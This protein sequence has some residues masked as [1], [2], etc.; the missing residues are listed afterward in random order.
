MKKD[1]M[2]I[3]NQIIISLF[4]LAL[5]ACGGSSDGSSKAPPLSIDEEAL[6]S[7]VGKNARAYSISG[8]CN[9]A[10]GDITVSVTESDV[11]GTLTCSEEHS[12]SGTVDFSALVPDPATIFIS[13]GEVS[14]QAAPVVNQS[15]YFITKWS[16][17][18]G[19]AF[20]L[21]LVSG[22]T[23]DFIVDWGD[24]DNPCVVDTTCVINSDT[25]G[26]AT[27]TYADE[28]DYT[29]IIKG[30]LD[31]FQN[32]GVT[33]THLKEVSNLGNVGWK[34]LSS[35]FEGNT[36]L[37]KFYGGNTSE[38]TNMSRMFANA[39]LVTPYVSG[40]D[41]SV[42]TDMSSMFEG[43]AEAQPYTKFWDTSAVTNMSMM[44][45]GAV[46]AKPKATDWDTSAVANMASMFEG[47]VEANPDTMDWD[48]SAV[49]NMSMMFKGA[50]EAEPDTSTWITSAV[51][52]MSEMFADATMANPDTTT[53]TFPAVTSFA[54]MFNVGSEGLSPENYS[55]FLQ[56]LNGNKPT[57]AITDT[58]MKTFGETASLIP[59]SLDSADT[60]GID[61]LTALESDGYVFHDEPPI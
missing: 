13:Q 60:D 8:D 61:A 30:A 38:V 16:F 2:S 40:W 25:D 44:F 50:L 32:A 54:Q 53:W 12:Y 56:S 45:K 41:T 51:T 58:L 11:K 52:D 19:Q 33:A 10:N 39:A 4:C 15:Q 29:I 37:T 35:A 36:E 22:A 48:T 9:Y 14:V 17:S 20:T 49:T 26:D 28:G 5:A 57:T 47:A 46:K 59:V 23:Y 6:T 24:E 3:H 21:P 34:N 27:H 55:I 1:I 42:V 43:A 31:A 7:V 18:A